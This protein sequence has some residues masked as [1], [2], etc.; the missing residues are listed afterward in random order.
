[1]PGVVAVPI[2]LILAQAQ[3][4]T[5]TTMD[6]IILEKRG[7]IIDMIIQHG[8]VSTENMKNMSLYMAMLTG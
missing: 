2:M 6:T 3:T 5:K 7:M 8:E 4:P 1:M